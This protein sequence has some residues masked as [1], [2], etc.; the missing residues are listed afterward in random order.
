MVIA[1]IAGAHPSCVMLEVGFDVFEL[2]GEAGLQ[3]VTYSVA[4][5][6]DSADKFALLATWAAT[7]ESKPPRAGR[8]TRA[9]S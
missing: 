8:R 2:H 6:T 7:R 4:P 3:I 1:R 9:A 5:G